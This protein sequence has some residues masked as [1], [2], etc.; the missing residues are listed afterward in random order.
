[1]SRF[2]SQDKGMWKWFSHRQGGEL[3]VPTGG[4]GDLS[5]VCITV[6]LPAVTALKRVDSL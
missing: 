4:D 3:L 2:G 6:A 5:G 1:M